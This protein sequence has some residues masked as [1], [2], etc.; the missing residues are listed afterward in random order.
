MAEWCVENE[1]VVAD[2][3]TLNDSVNLEKRVLMRLGENKPAAVQPMLQV[4]DSLVLLCRYVSGDQ[5]PI[6]D[7]K[8]QTMKDVL[9]HHIDNACV[10]VDFWV[11]VAMTEHRLMA[12]LG[13]K[14]L[15]L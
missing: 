10:F 12:Q 4:L 6:L 14:S 13:E 5:E 3:D 8:F 1:V 7:A 15:R 9:S 2:K 11:L